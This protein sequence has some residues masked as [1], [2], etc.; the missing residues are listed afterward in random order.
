MRTSVGRL[1]EVLRYLRFRTFERFL[2]LFQGWA[3]R[4][5]M[6]TML[7]RLG[8]D[9]GTTVLDLGGQ[10]GTWDHDFVPR[11][12]ITILNLPGVAQ[13]PRSSTQPHRW[14]YVEGDACSLE[15]F[16]DRSFDFVF[17]NSVIEHVGNPAR[18]AQFAREVQRLGTRYWV[19][20]PSI[21][22]P[23]EA[24]TGMPFWW[25][26]PTALRELILRRWHKKLPA[27][28]DMVRGT[29][30]VTRSE[31]RRLFPQGTILVERFLGLPKSYIVI[32]I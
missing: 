2:G 19:Q 22:F 18:R 5:R 21:W 28:T 24:H 27:W 31:L 4:R 16:A 10:P 14:S 26:Y 1:G 20:T 23:L 32:A 8:V 12:D 15:R 6:R 7:A 25:F 11:L 13:H 17:S 3:R 29:T 9:S 30:V